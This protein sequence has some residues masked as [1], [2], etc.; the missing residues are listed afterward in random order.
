MPLTAPQALSLILITLIWGCNWSVMK[1]GVEI[2]PPLMFRAACFWIAIPILAAFML[3]RNI[4]FLV[5]RGER[6]QLVQLAATNMVLWNILMILALPLLSSGRAAILGYTMPVF[7]AIVGAWLY[8]ASMGPRHW[9]G[10]VAALAGAILLLWHEVVAFTGQPTGVFMAL[11][12]AF[13]WGLGTQML[14][15]ARISMHVAT[16]TFWA[17]LLGALVMTGLSLT[18]E[19][20]NLRLPDAAGV[21]VVLYNSL[22]V[23]CVA[24]VAWF[25]L[26]R[27]LP[28]QA[29]T[30]SVM[31]IPVL[32]VFS[33]AL[34]LGEQ[35]HWQDGLAVVLMLSAMLS[36]LWPGNKAVTPAEAAE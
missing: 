33:G 6:K 28:P 22:L 10:I 23:L 36:V 3:W 4:S 32:G 20:H 8:Q 35:V 7:A 12:A 21:A 14:R 26:A 15:H 19:Y 1:I 29:S 18:F 27:G 2:M 24:Q 17:L 34:L 30:L 16:F 9:F 31:M 5:P 11:G 25:Y 13:F